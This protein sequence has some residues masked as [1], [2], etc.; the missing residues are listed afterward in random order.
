MLPHKTFQLVAQHGSQF[1]V[2]DRLRTELEQRGWSQ[3]ELSRRLADLKPR[4]H[5]SQGAIS[6]MLAYDNPREITVD[7]LL[8]FVRVFNIPLE[9]FVLPSAITYEVGGW[10]A[11]M[12]A[13][14]KL[15]RLYEAFEEYDAAVTKARAMVKEHVGLSPRLKWHRERLLEATPEGEAPVELQAVEDILG[16]API[17]FERVADPPKKGKPS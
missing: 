13:I 11:Y 16:S 1:S 14:D 8:A 15:E 6:R 4:Y 3:S 9:E 2:V 7:D 12:T 5:L 10:G 17:R